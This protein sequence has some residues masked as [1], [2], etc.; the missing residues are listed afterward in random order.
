MVI[1]T[2]NPATNRSIPSIPLEL[3]TTQA[4]CELANGRVSKPALVVIKA[5]LV[6]AT[7]TTRHGHKGYV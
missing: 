4:L 6:A 2:N 3:L 1:N 7:I 5:V